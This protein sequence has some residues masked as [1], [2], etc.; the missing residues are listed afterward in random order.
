MPLGPAT[1]MPLY[2]IQ[3]GVA[4]SEGSHGEWGNR[5]PASQPLKLSSARPNRASPAHAFV[6][7]VVRASPWYGEGPAFES[8]RRL[9]DVAQQAARHLARV[10]AAGSIPVIHSAL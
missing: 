2:G 5:Q 10:Q 6:A 4:P 8:R 7:P 1:R 3:L 9:V